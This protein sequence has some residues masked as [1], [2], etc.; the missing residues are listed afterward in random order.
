MTSH[1]P[2][3]SGRA[4]CL[5]WALACLA[6]A[7]ALVI[8]SSAA[9]Q[10]GASPHPSAQAPAEQG[11]R[12]QDLKPAQ[13]VALTPLKRDWSSLDVTRKRKWLR[14]ASRYS[15]LSAPEQARLQARMT[16]WSDMTPQQ[17]GRARLNFRDAKELPAED[18]QARWEAYQALSPEQKQQL[19][20]RAAASRL[21]HRAHRSNSKAGRSDRPGR[22]QSTA[23]V[24]PEPALAVPPR[25]VA[26]TMVRASRGAT[27]TLISRQ[28]PPPVHNEARQPR[29]A[30]TPDLVDSA[31]LLPRRVPARPRDAAPPSRPAPTQ[32]P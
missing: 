4:S 15:K 23:H 26:P 11:V 12:W 8:G 21:E 32:K 28:P 22:E 16:E 19:A 2:H 29:I 31:T 1:R 30:A 13:Q 18:R 20:E 9:A 25:P 5:R 7:F 3:D 24:P 14:I 6:G 10:S 27:T 17:R